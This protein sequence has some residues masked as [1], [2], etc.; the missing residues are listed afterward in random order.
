MSAVLR[1]AMA[2]PGASALS[3]VRSQRQGTVLLPLEFRRDGAVT[4]WFTTVTSFGAPQDAMAE[5]IT[6]EQ[7]H[8][9]T[10]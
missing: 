9:N 10:N 1:R 5:E 6:I 4:R 3:T 2:Q 7:F 8:P